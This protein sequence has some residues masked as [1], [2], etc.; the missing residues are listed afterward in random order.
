MSTRL[1]RIM[2]IDAKIRQGCY[3][4]ISTFRNKFEVSERTIHDD[5]A[6][7]RDRL[8]APL[9]YDR[10]NRG[11]IYNDEKWALPAMMASEGELLAFFLSLELSSR[12]L[13]TSFE[14]PLR[15]TIQRLLQ[16]LPIEHHIELEDLAKHYTFQSGAVAA[17]NAD[18]LTALHQAINERYRV[19]IEYFTASRGERNERII[20]PYHLYNV[21][22]NWQVIAFDHLRQQTRNFAVT[23]IEAWEM[24]WFERFTPD[25]GF[26]AQTYL[27]KG[28]LAERGDQVIDISIWFD[29]Y[30]A[31]Y[32]RDRNWHASQTIE[33]HDDG[34][35]SLHFQNGA[36]G[37]IKRWVMSFGQHAV[38][39]QPQ[40][41]I[42]EI[43]QEL[44]AS[45]SI[46]ENR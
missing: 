7:L 16:A 41:L 1:E 6:F 39:L 26:S 22:G 14:Q 44:Q 37:E 23:R 40:S 25:P 18:L 42:D 32:I 11:Y 5:L 3:P 35:L 31:T 15:S 43:Y 19:K 2:Y 28:F 36:L 13:G 27:D 8:N 4:S 9:H 21:Q 12:Y 38:V 46:Y 24:L 33:E 30:Q 45:L 34:S 17:S 10:L 29:S 20:E